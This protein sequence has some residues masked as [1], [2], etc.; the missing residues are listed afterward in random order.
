MIE[1]RT[2]VTYQYSCIEC[3]YLYSEQRDRGTLAFFT[4]CAVCNNDYKTINETEYTY[5]VHLPDPV[6]NIE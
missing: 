2:A 6:Q 3:G 1:I 5:E 4:K